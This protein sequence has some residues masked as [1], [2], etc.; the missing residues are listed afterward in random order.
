ML[1]NAAKNEQMDLQEYANPN[2]IDSDDGNS[3]E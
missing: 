1:N 2:K 3:K